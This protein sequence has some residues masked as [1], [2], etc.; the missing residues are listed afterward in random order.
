[1][2]GCLFDMYRLNSWSLF[3]YVLCIIGKRDFKSVILTNYLLALRYNDYLLEAKTKYKN[4][5]LR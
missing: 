5:F 2:K 3:S 4:I 1:M